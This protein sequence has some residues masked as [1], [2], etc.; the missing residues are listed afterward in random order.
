MFYAVCKNAVSTKFIFYICTTIPFKYYSTSTALPSMT[1]TDLLNLIL[2]IPPLPE[3][4]AIA[5]FLDEK[6]NKIDRAVAQK[7]KLVAL[8]KE[9]KQIV[10][11]NAVT[12]GLNPN[13]KMKDSGVEWIGEIPEGWEIKRLRL[14]GHTQN[15]ISASAEYFGSGYPFI[16]YGDVYNSFELPFIVNGLANS[17]DEDRKQYS[18]KKGDVLFTRTSETIEEIGLAS[19]CMKTVQNSTFS[20]FLIRFRPKTN[21]LFEGFSK[22]YFNASMLR[23]YFVKEMNLVTRAS[24]NQDLLK[25]LPVLI[26]SFD[27][28][29]RIFYYIETQSQKINKAITL[30]QNQ[31]EKLKEYKSILINNAVTGKIKVC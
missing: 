4:T 30:Q 22:Y 14:I 29:Q 23:S 31:I 15:G 12:K 19:T 6:C 1:Q 8:L 26:P 2:F 5:N 21:D 24:L 20:G 13:A 18:I 25:N 11:Q 9:R 3:Q 28:Q 27:E 17:S 10:I 7:E 16:S